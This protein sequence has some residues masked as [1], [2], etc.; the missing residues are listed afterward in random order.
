[1]KVLHFIYR[2]DRMFQGGGR[3]MGAY[4]VDKYIG[5]EWGELLNTVIIVT[6]FYFL[7]FDHHL[8]ARRIP[9]E[10]LRFLLYYAI[11]FLLQSLYYWLLPESNNGFA[12]VPVAFAVVCVMIDRR[13]VLWQ[14]IVRMSIF[15]TV[16]IYS[17]AITLPIV[18][19][20]VNIPVIGEC[21]LI[22]ATVKL[23]LYAGTILVLHIFSIENFSFS[24]YF[25]T[26]IEAICAI[27][28]AL[29]LAGIYLWLE[30]EFVDP[31]SSNFFM[32][33]SLTVIEISAYLMFY[34]LNEEFSKKEQ[35]F[36]ENQ[37]IE[38]ELKMLSRYEIGYNR[39]RSVKHDICNQFA[40]LGVMLRNGQYDAALEYFEQLQIFVGSMSKGIY[41]ENRIINI[42]LDL[43]V[44]QAEAENIKVNISVAVPKKLE[45]SDTQLA[46]VIGNLTSNSLEACRALGEG[47]EKFI[48]IRISWENGYL[49]LSTVNPVD[50]SRLIIKNGNLMTNKTDKKEHGCG[51]E[52][53][54]KIAEESG[55]C[56]DYEI[57]DGKFITKVMIRTDI[58][59]QGESR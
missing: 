24:V 38:N 34:K 45:I 51:I 15:V 4:F 57:S 22:S 43:A 52:I 56:F 42:A 28:Y 41:T 46:S 55:G 35:L 7:Y 39:V 3:R 2:C 12:I 16:I 54:R 14:R 23:L 20:E 13:I 26:L 37:R 25:F 10:I 50:K 48:N 59:G 18:L 33:I 1:M 40:Y 21:M 47:T 36:I 31:F 11:Y 49:L 6:G 53:I 30:N 58:A 44:E 27:G 29:N 8:K 9:Y 19:L 5:M 32:S 17:Q